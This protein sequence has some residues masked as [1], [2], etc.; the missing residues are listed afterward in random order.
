MGSSCANMCQKEVE[1]E[2]INMKIS[3]K[4]VQ[5]LE[6]YGQGASARR[7]VGKLKLDCLKAITGKFKCLSSFL[8]EFLF[9]IELKYPCYKDDDSQ[10]IQFQDRK[11]MN[12]DEL[13]RFMNNL[14]EGKGLMWI[15][16]FKEID[17]NK[18]YKG[19]WKS[20]DM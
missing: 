4:N 3:K 6:R 7:E 15:N 1:F 20:Q 5:V 12:D 2:Q 19:H 16:Y 10:K 9:V 11:L 17:G 8:I 18:Q 13:S 14:D